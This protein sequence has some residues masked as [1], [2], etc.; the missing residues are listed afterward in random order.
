MSVVAY[1]G[2]PG[3]GKSLTVVQSVILPALKKGRHVVTNL[4]MRA[5]K[6]AALGLPGTLDELPMERI[7]AEPGLLFDYAQKGAIVIIDE[8]YK[9]FPAGVKAN[10]VP[11]EFHS[12]LNEHRHRVD[13]LGNSQ[14]IVVLTPDLANVAAFLRQAVET[15]YRCKKLGNVGMP[16]HFRTEVYDGCVTG[17]SPPQSKRLTVLVGAY[18]KSVFPLYV[19]HTQ[20][21]A[22][23]AGANEASIDRRF[24]IWRNPVIKY[25]APLALGVLVA[26]LYSAYG[27]YRERT[28]A[29]PARAVGA[30]VAA[31]RPRSVPDVRA[32]AAPAAPDY[33]VVGYT[34]GS[35]TATVAIR[36]AGV[37]VFVPASECWQPGDALMHC[38]FSGWEVTELG[39]SRPAA[40]ER[41][42]TA[43][44]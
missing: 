44:R 15:T 21:D 25:G 34:T 12:F 36:A 42:L 20:S 7:V 38:S 4:A 3:A 5:D 17:Q 31:P 32:A 18:D 28:A 14:Q 23:T 10:H 19:S 40:P 9:Y 1:V 16:S 33:R 41:A 13:D 24:V 8:A 2:L 29:P 37:L 39:A 26:S 22:A 30:S 35:R 43:T 27:W 6:V 11:Q